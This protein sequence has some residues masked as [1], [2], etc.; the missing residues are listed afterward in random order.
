MSSSEAVTAEPVVAA[1]ALTRCYGEQVAVD[2]VDLE[3]A[4]GT[5]FGFI[6]P[7]GSGKTTTVRL[8]TG[9]EGPS[10][11]EVRV[12][13]M[14]PTSFTARDRARIGYM[15][16]LAS[17]YPHLSLH[18]NLTFVASLYGVPLR[19]QRRLTKV[20]DFVEL[21][22][23]RGKLLRDV[24]GGMQR[25]L[26]LAATLLHEPDLIFLDEPTAGIDPVLRRKF[27]E[28]FTDLKAQG[29]TVFMTTQYVGE[30]ADCDEVGVLVDGRL[31]ARDTPDALRRTAF[32]GDLVDVVA[33]E[34]LG[35]PLVGR[36]RSL[37]GMLAA[38]RTRTDG[39][40]LRLVVADADD[41]TVWLQDWFDEHDVP[42]VSLRHHVPTF[43]DVFVK[44]IEEP[45]DHA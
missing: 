29:K 20:L 31:I 17:L 45:R 1:R 28:H 5:I 40:G 39:R 24:S 16:Q 15:P 27:W 8:L 34:A 11:G 44:L 9:I 43:D 7:S 22:S 33:A 21:T 3:V 36:I 18:E 19:R 37:R 6:G 42:L 10:S 12:F 14:P 26:S 38:R 41:A 30:S 4:A 13:G 2:D 25:R 23:H 35:D 32:G